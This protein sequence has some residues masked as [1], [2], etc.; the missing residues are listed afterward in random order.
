ML[1]TIYFSL[2]YKNA[3]L[4]ISRFK[5]MF[6]RLNKKYKIKTKSTLK[7]LIYTLLKVK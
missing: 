3:T 7:V 6:V 1:L 4:F 2:L 5:Q